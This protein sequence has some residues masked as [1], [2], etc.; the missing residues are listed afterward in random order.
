MHCRDSNPLSVPL[1]LP[2]HNLDFYWIKFQQN[3]IEELA[4]IRAL[5]KTRQIK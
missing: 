4:K 1:S 3:L 2:P 5:Q